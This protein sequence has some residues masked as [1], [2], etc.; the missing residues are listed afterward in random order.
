MARTAKA[1]RLW[2]KNYVRDTRMQLLMAQDTVMLLDAAQEERQLEPDELELRK[3]LKSRILGL[4]VIERI[5]ARQLAR[6]NWIRVGDA[7]TRFFHLKTNARRRKNFI[8]SLAGAHGIATEH[9]HNA[10]VIKD[11]FGSLLGTSAP[12]AHTMDWD[13]LGL[14]SLDLSEL[15]EAF[16]PEEILAAIADMPADRA[17][18]PDG[19]SG[20]FFKAAAP[21]IT[22]D[23]VLAFQQLFQ[24][25]RTSLHKMNEAHRLIAMAVEDGVLSRLPGQANGVRTSLYADDDVFFIRPVKEEFEAIHQILQYFGDVTGLCVNFAKTSVIPIRCEAFDV[26]DIVSPLGA[27]IAALPCKFLGL[28]LSLRKLRKVDFQPL[29]DRIASRLACW[30]AKLLSATGRLVLLNAVLSALVADKYGVATL[31]PDAWNLPLASLPSW[32]VSI[33]ALV[34][35]PAKTAKSLALLVIWAI[36]RERNARIFRDLHRSPD[37]A[38]REVFDEAASWTLAGCRHI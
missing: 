19:F 2:Q 21:I 23:L 37:A 1:L 29:L 15:D 16:T 20:A 31:R 25:N 26:P 6:V 22:H 12:A 17:P 10:A 27:R 7:N 36:W 35:V 18:G 3:A 30:K 38:A 4:V 13:A 11:F 24:L 5:R 28:P 33:S 14:P 34:G 9:G 32:L 8:P